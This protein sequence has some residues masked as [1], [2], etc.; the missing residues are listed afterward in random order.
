[1]SA[2]VKDIIGVDRAGTLY[3]GRTEHM[4][5]EKVWYAE[6]TNPAA[7]QGRPLTTRSKAPTSSSGCPA[8]EC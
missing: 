6:N 4:N 1:M 3:K 8:P 2:G 7:D 5:S